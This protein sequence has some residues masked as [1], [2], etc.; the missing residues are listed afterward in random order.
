MKLA[1]S[2]TIDG[3]DW[4]ETGGRIVLQDDEALHLVNAGHAELHEDQPAFE[5]PDPPKAPV[6]ETRP[7]QKPETR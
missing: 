2:G 1:M 3:Q 6:K 4:P 5:L 7:A